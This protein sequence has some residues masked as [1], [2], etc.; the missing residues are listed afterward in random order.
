VRVLVVGGGIGGLA[1]AIAVR[2]AG[3]EAV[4]L[5]RA[6]ALAAV[7]P[8]SRCPRMPWPRS[9]GSASPTSSAAAGTP[10]PRRSASTGMGACCS[11][12]RTRSAAGRCSA[13]T[14][15][16]SRRRFSAHCRRSRCASIGPAPAS[17]G[18][19]GACAATSNAGASEEGDVL[20]GADGLHSVVRIGLF[21]DSK[22]RYSGYAA[23]R[24]VTE[25]LP[26]VAED[27][28]SESWGPGARFGLIPIGGG[29]LYWFTAEDAPDGAAPPDAPLEEIRRRFGGWHDPIP[30][31]V[32]ATEEA[33]LSRT[34]VYDRPPTKRWGEGR[35]TLLGDAAHPMTP[36]LGQ[37]AAQALEDAVVLGAELGRGGD[38]AEALRRY[39]GRCRR[40]A[41]SIVKQSLQAGRLAHV[42]SPRACAVRDAVLRVL[43]N[44]LAAARQARVFEVSLD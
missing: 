41:N 16:T 42:S 34:F 8:E 13:S 5:E 20:V 32:D 31:V 9:S 21:G 30:A 36:N 24:A 23:W 26:G 37:G 18:S 2:M 14:A 7:G 28:F 15:P 11:R 38:P 3:Y 12:S 22:L 19:T 40:R 10:P 43:P 39:E 33:T 25:R 4:V 6:Q 35:V 44:R 17:S 29:R 1:A 27:T